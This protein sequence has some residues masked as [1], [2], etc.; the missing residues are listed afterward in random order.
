MVG[1][2]VM[3]SLGIVS[4]GVS[5]PFFIEAAGCGGD[6][7]GY[8][9][10]FGSG[11]ALTGILLMAIGIPLWVSGGAEVPPNESTAAPRL[12]VTAGPGSAGIA[13]QF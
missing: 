8:Y 1:G 4:T 3:T 10:A 9:V 2:I 5:V 11:F 6:F 12:R 7:C 13:L